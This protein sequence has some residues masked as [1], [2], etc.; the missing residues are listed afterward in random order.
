MA[1]RRGR[2]RCAPETDRRASSNGRRGWPTAWP[3]NAP[4]PAL[5]PRGR[6]KAR[7]K[8]DR[9]ATAESALRRTSS[10]LQRLDL[11]ACGSAHW[12]PSNV[13]GRRVGALIRRTRN[14]P[15]I[16]GGC[17][18]L[19]RHSRPLRPVARLTGSM[20]LAPAFAGLVAPPR[21]ARLGASRQRRALLAAVAPASVTAS[22][23]GKQS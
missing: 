14:F 16:G 7:P 21:T 5:S 18:R 17:A 4:S 19:M 9:S 20:S 13:G 15:Q 11:A 12:G 3:G 1:D 8:K 22:T 23:Y 6:V 10:R 2:P